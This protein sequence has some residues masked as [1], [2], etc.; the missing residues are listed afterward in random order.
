M[1]TK[2]IFRKS[3]LEHQK[4]IKIAQKKFDETRNTETATVLSNL[5]NNHKKALDEIFRKDYI[6]ENVKIAVKGLKE[7]DNPKLWNY[8]LEPI[9][10]GYNPM[11]KDIAIKYKLIE[12][13]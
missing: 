1:S 11:A 4:E 2:T 5:K 8:T 7:K 10:E 9:Y 12:A 3:Y 13:K 6:L